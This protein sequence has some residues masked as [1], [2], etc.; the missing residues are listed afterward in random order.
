TLTE[1]ASCLTRRHRSAGLSTVSGS[2]R[3]TDF[4]K[5]WHSERYQIYRIHRFRRC[6]RCHGAR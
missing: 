1:R 2:V 3:R 5:V 4:L 6:R